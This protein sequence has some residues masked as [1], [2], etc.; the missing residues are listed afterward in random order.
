MDNFEKLAQNYEELD[1]VRD[2]SEAKIAA[3]QYAWATLYRDTIGV[4][5]EQRHELRPMLEQLAE[6]GERTAEEAIERIRNQTQNG[7]SSALGPDDGFEESDPN[8]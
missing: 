8:F 4:L 5:I 7:L 2:L 3:R 6:T 1:G